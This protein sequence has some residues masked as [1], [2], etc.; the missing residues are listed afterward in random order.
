MSPSIFPT[1][2]SQKTL[3]V[4]PGNQPALPL[5]SVIVRSMGR[6]ELRVALESIARQ[7]YPNVEVIVV[8][9]TG[10]NHPTLPDIAWQSGHSIRIVGGHRQLPRPQAANEGLQAVHGEWFCFL[11]DDDT[12]DFDF[13]SAMLSA[14]REHSATLLVYGRTRMLDENGN[15]KK[16]FGGPFNRAMMYYGP[17]FYWQAAIIRRKVIELGCCFD[18][19]LEVCEDRDFLNQIAEHCD[20]V[21]VP[22]VG[23]NYRP[24]L[25]TSGTGPGANRD[26]SRTLRSENILRAKWADASSYH[27]RR[28]TEM[29][30]GAVRAFHEGNVAL[31]R[32]LFDKTLET[33]PDDPS[34]L[35]GLARLDLN[36]GQLATAEKL[37]R[38]AIEINP[39][40]AEFC[41]TMALILEASHKYEEALEFLWRARIN[42]TFQAGADKLAQRISEIAQANPLTQPSV[43]DVSLTSVPS[44]EIGHTQKI[45]KFLLCRPHGGLND[46]LCQI[47]KCWKYAEKFGRTLIIDTLNSGL[48]AEFSEFFSPRNSLTKVHFS[49][50][51]KQL[52]F[53]DSLTSFPHFAQGKLK[54]YFAVYSVDLGNYMDRETYEILTFNFDKNYDELVLIHEQ[55]DGGDLSFD[56][57]NRISISE[58]IRP[59]V[60]DRIQHLGHDYL[61]I[62]VRN[63]DYQTQYKDLFRDV[64]PYVNNKSLLICSDDAE[65]ISHAKNFFT[66]S[67]VLTSSQTP[68]TGNKPLHLSTTHS[69]DEQ[70]KKATINSIIDLIALGRS[71]KLYFANVTAG[72]SSG[73]SRLAMYLCQNKNVIDALLKSDTTKPS[74]TSP[75]QPLRYTSKP[76]MRWC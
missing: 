24:D 51:E 27:T 63:T 67:N 54:T 9:A 47:E 66:L 26:I 33:Y 55:S 38:R 72:H 30:M 21:F 7:D 64:Y 4:S 73:F 11:D 48:L 20:F 32:T 74:S 1:H 40:A 61:A 49:L 36:D 16:L 35:H 60:L 42:P 52:R 44:P 50:S 56:L 15:V 22:V 3:A 76:S 53:L 65:V 41:M 43:I 39:S 25:G 13:L 59:I 58:N 23:F 28:L 71:S 37:V 62:H 17:L 45:E 75:G 46:T 31:S 57:F 29:C 12:Y 18:E 6:P 68:Q 19:A 14:S 69:D 5:V 34:A 2:S 8:D 70:R 10:G